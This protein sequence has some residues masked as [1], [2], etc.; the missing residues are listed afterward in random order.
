MRR[1]K[2]YAYSPHE[3]EW[4]RFQIVDHYKALRITITEEQV[5]QIS[6]TVCALARAS[7]IALHNAFIKTFQFPP[8][9]SVPH[10]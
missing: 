9:S 1:M 5:G 2:D 4:L 3:I 6:N 10:F 7:C 8:A